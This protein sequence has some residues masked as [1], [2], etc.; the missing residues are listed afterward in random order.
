MKELKGA[1]LG[2]SQYDCPSRLPAVQQPSPGFLLDKE[3][4]HGQHQIL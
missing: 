4:H 2:L 1:L 3:L